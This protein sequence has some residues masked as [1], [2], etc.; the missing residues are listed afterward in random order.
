MGAKCT[1]F[2]WGKCGSTISSA[3]GNVQPQQCLDCV[4]HHVSGAHMS[5]SVDQV[6]QAC[7]AARGTDCRKVFADLCLHY[8][9]LACAACVKDTDSQ[10][11]LRDAGCDLHELQQICKTIK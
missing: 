10:H 3:E 1:A 9:G 6:Y 5:C 2:V 11:K 7:H 8:E 4:R